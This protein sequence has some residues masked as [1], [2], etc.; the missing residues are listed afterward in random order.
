MIFLRSNLSIFIMKQLSLLNS[1]LRCCFAAGC[2]SQCLILRW[3]SVGAA[4]VA[5]LDIAP[6]NTIF[7]ITFLD[8]FHFRS[9][10]IFGVIN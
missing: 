8:A 4:F 9:S 10:F 1:L 7:I 5:A 6:S 3:R 2:N